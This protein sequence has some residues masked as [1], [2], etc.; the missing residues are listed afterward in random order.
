V[1]TDRELHRLAAM[2]PPA[3]REPAYVLFNNLPRVEG[4]RRFREIL[5]EWPSRGMSEPGDAS[6]SHA[7]SGK[8]HR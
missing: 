8:D 2:L 6:P 7:E 1:Y 5:G 4:A 3:P